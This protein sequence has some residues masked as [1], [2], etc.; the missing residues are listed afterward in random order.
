MFVLLQV[1]DTIRRPTT[2]SQW[3][4]DLG[5]PQYIH[6]LVEN[7]WDNMDFINDLTETDLSEASVN[8]AS[9]RQKILLSIA[10]MTN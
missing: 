7:G 6:G 10:N 1:Y 4:M 9:H 3:L 8:V 2:I 5:L